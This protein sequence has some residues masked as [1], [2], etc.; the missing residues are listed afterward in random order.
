LYLYNGKELQEE[1][2]IDMYDYGARMYD[3]QLGRW[4][5]VD[6]MAEK[7]YNWSPYRYGYDSPIIMTDPTGMREETFF[8]RRA[9]NELTGGHWSDNI[10]YHSMLDETNSES[11]SENTGEGKGDHNKPARKAENNTGPGAP[12]STANINLNKDLKDDDECLTGCHNGRTPTEDNSFH[13]V[14]LMDP[15]SVTG[16]IEFYDPSL[17]KLFGY[18]GFS[19]SYGLIADF[20]DIGRIKIKKFPNTGCGGML[21][22]S[23]DATYYRSRGDFNLFIED[24]GGS[25]YSIGGGYKLFNAEYSVGKDNFYGPSNYDA[26]TYSFRSWSFKNAP[27]FKNWKTETQITN[28]TKSNPYLYNK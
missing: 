7:A 4:H 5:S 25:G 22:L 16:T 18:K 13:D 28:L 23:L 1:F 12:V 17:D 27:S 3:P 19:R 8:H 15:L 14:S 6:P 2:D 11:S 9:L 21:N 26:I 10:Q 20:Y 24:V